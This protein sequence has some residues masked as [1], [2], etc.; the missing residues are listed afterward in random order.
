MI[1]VDI[2]SLLEQNK[3]VDSITVNVR[4]MNDQLE[5]VL[6]NIKQQVS[7]LATALQKDT[8]EPPKKKSKQ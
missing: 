2:E 1:K 8:E 7:E 4:C 3:A 6:S 5:N